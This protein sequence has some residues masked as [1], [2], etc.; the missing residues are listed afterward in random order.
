MTMTASDHAAYDHFRRSGY[1]VIPRALEPV[2]VAELR[3]LVVDLLD[4]STDPSSGRGERLDGIYARHEA[5]SDA[6]RNPAL[7]ESLSLLLGPNILLCTNRHNHATALHTSNRSSRLHRDI[8][9][10]SRPVVSALIYLDNT[11]ASTGATRLL[12]GSQYV[13]CTGKPNNGGTWLDE[14]DSYSTLSSQ[15]LSVSVNAGDVLLLDSLI[16]HAAG[17]NTGPRPRVVLAFSYRSVDELVPPTWEDPYTVLVQ[18]EQL[19]RGRA[20]CTTPPTSAQSSA[21]A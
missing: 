6:A 1:L 18:G 7:V 15:E 5:F 14:H 12:P 16:Y 4:R 17:T 9:Q 13:P 19:Y 3:S 2:T 11:D 10:W 21:R 8:L 20:L